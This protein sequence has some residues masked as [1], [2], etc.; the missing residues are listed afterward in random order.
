LLQTRSFGCAG[1]QRK[2]KS[3]LTAEHRAGE[4]AKLALLYNVQYWRPD[5][6]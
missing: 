4:S 3:G 5:V 1:W 6:S 2:V